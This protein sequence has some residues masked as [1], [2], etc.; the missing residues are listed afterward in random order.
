MQCTGQRNIITAAIKNCMSSKR[1]R[2]DEGWYD[3][4]ISETVAMQVG[5]VVI[6]KETGA[7]GTISEV[8]INA[9]QSVPLHQLSYKIMWI[10][11]TCKEHLHNSW[12][13]YTEIKMAVFR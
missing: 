12:F 11:E 9:C 4:S 7:V 8:S 13:D 1:S 5:T 3:T 10:R 6:H 2:T